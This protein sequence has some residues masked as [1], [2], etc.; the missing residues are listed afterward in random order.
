ME[1]SRKPRAKPKPAAP[2]EAQVALV[3][4]A[5]HGG[6]CEPYAAISDRRKTRWRVAVAAAFALAGAK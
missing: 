3:R 6:V 1:T 4:A 5:W 2:T